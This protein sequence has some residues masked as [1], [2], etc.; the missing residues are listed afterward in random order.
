MSAK[1]RNSSTFENEQLN[2]H[3]AGRISGVDAVDQG[4]ALRRPLLVGMM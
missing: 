2:T 4:G 3:H 1:T